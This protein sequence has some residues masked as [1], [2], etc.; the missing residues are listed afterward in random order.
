VH[1]PDHVIV[2]G[3]PLMVRSAR[4]HGAVL[5]WFVRRMAPNANAAGRPCSTLARTAIPCLC[6]GVKLRWA[7]AQDSIA[8]TLK[9][10]GIA[11]LTVP[12]HPVLW[13]DDGAIVRVDWEARGS[14]TA[15]A[16]GGGQL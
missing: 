12:T 13:E 7:K 8:E 5:A 9:L 10:R 15:A 3:A 6:I 14:N 4:R 1:Q 11:H 16:R 2:Q